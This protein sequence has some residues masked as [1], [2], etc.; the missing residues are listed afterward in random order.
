MGRSQPKSMTIHGG[1]SVIAEVRYSVIADRLEKGW[2]DVETSGLDEAIAWAEEAR[3]ERKA[4]ST[5][6]C[7]KVVDICE[8]AMSRIWIPDIVAEMC[9]CHDPYAVVPSGIAP[10]QA[11]R[12][13][14]GDR[15]RNLR[16]SRNSILR[17]DRVMNAFLDAGASVFEYGTFAGMEAADAGMPQTEAFRFP[18]FVARYWR[19]ELFE[20]GR[21]PFRRTCV[22][23]E[24]SDRERQD[25]LS[26]ELFPDCATARRWIQV[27]RKHL[28]DCRMEACQLAC[29]SLDS[30]GA[31]NLPSQRT[32]WSPAGKS[33]L[34]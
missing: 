2:I 32:I 4:L 26:L 31:R 23:G 16:E 9:P 8:E 22:S 3:S 19:P 18:G 21:G 5:A 33:R 14:A 28:P 6:I 15:E 24:V 11:V 17:M 10:E 13:R 27:A 20:R 12:I 1:V 30:A 25:E 29:A 7:G 34:P